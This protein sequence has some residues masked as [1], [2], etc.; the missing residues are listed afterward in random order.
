MAVEEV[1][2]AVV[3]IINQ[4]RFSV[5][6]DSGREAAVASLPFLFCVKF[7]SEWES[8]VRRVNRAAFNWWT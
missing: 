3:A 7:S 8:G 1:S 5:H 2:T 6:V 4:T